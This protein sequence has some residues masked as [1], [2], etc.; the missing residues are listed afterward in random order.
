MIIF[1]GYMH[2]RQRELIDEAERYRL[3]SKVKNSPG[4]PNHNYARVMNW[5]GS[6][7]LKL[8]TWLT[9]RFGEKT[10][11]AQSGIVDNHIQGT[12]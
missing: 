2:L 1:E 10:I 3:A 6:Q 5:I 9:M 12:H 8:G 7:M 11:I 4:R